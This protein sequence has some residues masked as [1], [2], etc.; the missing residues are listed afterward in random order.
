LGENKGKIQLSTCGTTLHGRGIK[1]GEVLE[2][3]DWLMKNLL[4]EQSREKRNLIDDS[5]AFDSLILPQS[6]WSWLIGESIFI[7]GKRR[8]SKSFSYQNGDGFSYT[9]GG[10]GIGNQSFRE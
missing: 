7:A 6:L 4:T 2:E 9:N 8:A 5:H 10:V 3:G 1:A